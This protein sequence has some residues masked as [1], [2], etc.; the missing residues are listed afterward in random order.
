MQREISRGESNNLYCSFRP[1]KLTFHRFWG[2]FWIDASSDET[3]QHSFKEIA[4]IGGV[5]TNI[6][7]A[8]TWLSSL[9]RPWLLV[10]DN[11]DDPNI[12]VE[13]YFPGG[14]RG[15]ILVTT[16]NPFLKNFGTVG[17]GSCELERLE[18]DD[19]VSLLLKQA[20][21][22]SPWNSSAR[23]HAAQIARVLG[24]LPLALVYTGKAIAKGLTTLEDC[25][26]YF[27]NIWDSI[28]LESKRSGH[29]VEEAGKSVF[30][31][32]DAMYQDLDRQNTQSARDA[33][34]LLKLFSFL[35]HENIRID[36]ITKAAKNSPATEARLRHEYEEKEHGSFAHGQNTVIPQPKPWGRRIGEW[37]VQVVA[38]YQDRGYPTLPVALRD[39]NVNSFSVHRLRT[40]LSILTQMS[41]I[42]HRR[43]NDQDVYSMHPLVHRW[44]RER[45][46]MSIGERGL[47]CQAAITMLN[48]CVP[49]PPLGGADSDLELRRH[50]LPHLDYVQKFQKE[51]QANFE[52]NQ[53][54]RILPFIWLLRTPSID[55]A[56]AL[57]FAKFSRV[58][59]ECGRFQDAEMLQVKV[60]NYLTEMLGLEDERTTLIMLALSGTYW[61]LSRI[62][63]ATALLNQALEIC[64]NSLGPSHHRTLKVMDELGR[65]QCFRGRFKEALKLHQDAL[66]G[67]ERI[68]PPD[69]TDIFLAM[70]NLGVVNHRYFRYTESKEL[71]SQAVTGLTKNL[72]STHQTTLLAK[73]N[74]AM[75]YLEMGGEFLDSALKVEL[76]VLEQRRNKLGKENP[77]TLWAICN[78]A[79]IKSALGRMD[80]A[81]RE[82]RAT[83]P[84]AIRNLGEN[85][86]GTLSGK[87]H[88]AQ[89][90][91]RQKRYDEAKEI[92]KDVIQ[93]SRYEAGTREEGEH[94]DQ[95]MAMW[96]AAQL[97]QLCGNFEEAMH[98]LEIVS[99]SLSLIG[100]TL[101]PFAKKLANKMEDLRCAIAQKDARLNSGSTTGQ[102]T[103]PEQERQTKATNSSPPMV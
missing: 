88:L 30:A 28:R 45:P 37:I 18:E 100:G 49:L 46:Q 25:V 81:E 92:F 76:E 31:P 89:V 42:I 94:P 19:A 38:Q 12:P 58:Y 99:S 80:E 85:H 57:Q 55:R 72:G 60:K 10:I 82:M 53:R 61:Q 71:H 78:L 33:I 103:E 65:S 59:S 9:E 67:M 2:V 35:H 14:E 91:V 52:K 62:N 47:W 79:R 90:L 64:T 22:P 32:Y 3:A 27:D 36:F 43:M 41:L 21:E 24:Y 77:Y 101:H 75:A 40:A 86:F 70:D 26:N 11:A 95:I 48:Q 7:A 6:N 63:E 23:L 102:D 5:D 17:E 93:R 44:V 84:I 83:L 54:T 74:L 20:Q 16:R 68:L 39:D 4:Q 56:K 98:L 87:T 8:K 50:L 29:V 73:E 1:W 15:H 51:I 13:R 66:S 34:E 69:H 96:Y 97:H